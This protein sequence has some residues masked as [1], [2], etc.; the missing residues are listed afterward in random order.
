VRKSVI[1]CL[2]L[3]DLEFKL[4]ADFEFMAR[5]LER[6]KIRSAYIPNVLVRMRL[7]GATN[8]SWKN[9]LQQNKE[10]LA[11]LEKNEVCFSKIWFAV[12]KIF[13]RLGQFVIGY[14]HRTD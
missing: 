14:M 10:I 4:A 2:G 13:D 5:Y 9:V 7:G 8:Q 6:G 1:E 3:F 11:A 12:N